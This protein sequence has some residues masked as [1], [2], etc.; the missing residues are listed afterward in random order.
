[1]E[2]GDSHG[3]A[4]TFYW[5]GLSM[6]RHQYLGDR[7]KGCVIGRERW[8]GAKFNHKVTQ[9]R[10]SPKWGRTGFPGLERVLFSLEHS[11]I[12]HNC[13]VLHPLSKGRVELCCYMGFSVQLY[14]V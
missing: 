7:G 6:C 8:V 12:D 3:E 13:T 4:N 9:Y 11:S 5:K 2:Q 14:N 1:M 10:L